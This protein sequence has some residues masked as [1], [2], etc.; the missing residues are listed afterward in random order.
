MQQCDLGQQSVLHAIKSK[1]RVKLPSTS[2]S[3]IEESEEEQGSKPLC[4]TLKDLTFSS[5]EGSI[6]RIGD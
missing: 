4:E 6:G 1:K 5:E 3:L 2:N